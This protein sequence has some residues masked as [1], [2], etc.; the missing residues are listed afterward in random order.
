MDIGGI[1]NDCNK[2]V[3][4]VKHKIHESLLKSLAW[5]MCIRGL[6]YLTSPLTK[7]DGS[8][9][10]LSL[11]VVMGAEES[12]ENFQDHLCAPTRPA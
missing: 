3:H 12:L 11:L 7:T 5:K 2:S 6:G 8:G 1:S 4:K 9:G 10:R